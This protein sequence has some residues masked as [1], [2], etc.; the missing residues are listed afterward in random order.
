MKVLVINIKKPNWAKKVDL[1]KG[2]VMVIKS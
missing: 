2:E 1:T